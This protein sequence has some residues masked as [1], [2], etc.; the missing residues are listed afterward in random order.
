[1]VLHRQSKYIVAFNSA[2]A[3]DKKHAATLEKIYI[4]KGSIF[5]MM[6]SL[7]VFYE[8][9]NRF[10]Y[11]NTDI[12]KNLKTSKSSFHIWRLNTKK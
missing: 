12:A 2:G 10:F 3:I 11:M 8:C 7:E 5:D 9:E 1:M 6:L 4:K